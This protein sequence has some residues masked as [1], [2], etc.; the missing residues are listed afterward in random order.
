MTLP[1][2]HL[3]GEAVAALVDGELG[4]GAYHRA[5]SHIV[6]CEECRAAVDAQRETKVLL[7]TAGSPALP[8]GLLARL[9]E[10]P[11][12]TDLG[13]PSTGGT[14]AVAGDQLVWTD[15]PADLPGD[16]APSGSVRPAGRPRRQRR[17]R[18]ASYPISRVRTQ[19]FRRGIAMSVAGLAF[20]VLASVSPGSTAGVGLPSDPGTDPQPG[21][22][23]VPAQVVV[24]PNLTDL[25]RQPVGTPDDTGQQVT[26]LDT[27]IETELRST[28][29]GP[30]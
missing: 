13:G 21:Q 27:P 17:D 1:D 6:R 7:A 30:R 29:V 10:I 19:R 22:R 11:M 20:G 28:L 2:V 8:P 23:V 12:T 3:A 15:T 14:L 5:M 18:P 9:A 4:R 25:G 26:L 16:A 24:G